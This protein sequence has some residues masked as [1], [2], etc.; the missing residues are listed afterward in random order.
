MLAYN[1]KY[2]TTGSIIEKSTKTY[3][4]SKHD[5]APRLLIVTTG[6]KLTS[7]TAVA[8]TE[9]TSQVSPL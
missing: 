6:H 3:T 1:N 8:R 4:I 7:L 9:Q 5:I 2:L